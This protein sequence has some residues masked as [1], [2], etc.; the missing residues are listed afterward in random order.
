MIMSLESNEAEPSGRDD[1]GI[2]RSVVTAERLAFYSPDVA[3]CDQCREEF[4]N[5]ADRR[6][7]YPFITCINCGPRFSIVRDIPYDRTNTAMEPFLMCDR[8]LAEYTDPMDRRFHSQPN[9]CPVCG[10]RISLF[11]NKK[12]LLESENEAVA[13]RTAALLKEGAVLAIKGIDT[14]QQSLEAHFKAFDLELET[15]LLAAG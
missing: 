1:F 2:D 12:E 9:A 6:Y 8:C 10:P 15:L 13:Q 7:H 3:L 14:V 11:S 4:G 5:P